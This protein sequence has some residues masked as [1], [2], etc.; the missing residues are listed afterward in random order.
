MASSKRSWTVY[1]RG[2][3]GLIC[4]ILSL[5]LGWIV[6]LLGLLLGILAIGLSVLAMDRRIRYGVVLV[7]TAQL[8]GA[9]GFLM[10]FVFAGQGNV[11][12]VVAFIAAFLLVVLAV[13]YFKRWSFMR[14]IE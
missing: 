5:A 10:A 4:A 3:A 1:V 13:A 12:C 2:T 7:I 6:T 14:G 9:V 8:L 11:L